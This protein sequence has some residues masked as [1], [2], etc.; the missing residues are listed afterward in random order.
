MRTYLETY[1]YEIDEV[2]TCATALRQTE[3]RCP[4]LVLRDYALPDGTALD[5]L[6]QLKLNRIDVPVI[7]LTRVMD[8]SSWP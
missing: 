4:D 2:D 1:G 8:R 7:V 5:L 6:R 3:D